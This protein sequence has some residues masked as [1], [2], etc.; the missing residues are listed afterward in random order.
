MIEAK[1]ERR[2]IQLENAYGDPPS[3]AL[4][5]ELKSLSQTPQGKAKKKK[6]PK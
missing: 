1:D 6:K 5:A 2:A 3:E 4:A